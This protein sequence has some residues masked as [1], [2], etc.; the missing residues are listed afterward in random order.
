[1]TY[2][3]TYQTRFKAETVKGAVENT[4]FELLI[5]NAPNIA[6]DVRRRWLI[7][8]SID[9]GIIGKYRSPEYAMFKA[10][11]NP[12]AGG[13]VDLTLTGSLGEKINIKKAGNN[14][15]EVYSADEKFQKIGRQYGFEEFGLNDEQEHQLFEEL[16]DF[17]LS[18]IM[19]K[20]WRA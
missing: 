20:V 7:G 2:L 5:L 14:L 9:G 6:R 15:F 13:N 3:E 4:V 11:I 1:M 16:F 18:T 12:L 19:G 17:A 10:S 8:E